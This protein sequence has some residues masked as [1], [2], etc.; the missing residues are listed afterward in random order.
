MKL[1]VTCQGQGLDDAVDPRFGRAR[2]FLMVDSD[3]GE[4]EVVDNEQQLNAPQGAGIQSAECVA[5][6]DAQAVLT[7]HCG[8]KAFRALQAVNIDVYVGISG[9]V[10]E[11]VEQFKSG[12]LSPSASADVEGHW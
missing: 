10:G 11:A 5:R 1:A 2:C 4:V 8:P 3:T 7:G 12:K 6:H 9:S